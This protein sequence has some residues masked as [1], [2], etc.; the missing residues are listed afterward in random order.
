M[1]NIEKI[2]FP[3]LDITGANY[4]QWTGYVKRHLKSIG[5][6]ATIQEGNK[7]TEETKAKVDVFIHQHI[8]EMLEYEWN[9]LR[10]QYFKK[11][12]EYTS[13]L[14]RICRALRF[15]GQTVTE[16]DMLEKT[17]STFH[18]SNIN[19]Q[20][21]YRLQNFKRYSDLNVNRLI[22]EKNKELLMRNH[23]NRP[24]GSLAIPEA[25]VVNNK[26]TKNLEAKEDEVTLVGIVVVV[27]IMVT[28]VFPTKTIVTTE[29]VIMDV[30][31]VVVVIVV[32]EITLTMLHKLIISVRK[33]MKLVPP[34]T[35]KEPVSGVEVQITSLKLVAHLH[36]YVSFT[37]HLIKEK[38][39]KLGHPGSTMIK[40]IVENTHGHPLKDQKFSKIDKAP[41]CTSCS[42]E[43]LIVRPSQLKIKNE[44]PMFLE[45]IQVKRVRLDNAGEFISHAFND[46]YMS[47]GIVVEHP[48]ARVYT[49]NGLAELLIKRLQLIARPL[50]MRTKL[51]VSMW[52]HA[53][54]HA[55]SLI[56]MR[57][58]AD[59]KYSSIQLAFGQEPYIS[60]LRI[61]G[62]SVYV[63]I[64]PPQ[65]TKMGPQRRL[66]IYVRYETSS[67]IR[68]VEPLM[69]DV[70]T[71]CFADCHFNEVIFPPLGGEKKTHKKD[72]SWSE[73]FL[74]YLDPRTKQNTKRVT[75]SHISAANAPARVE[76][77][78]KQAV[79][80]VDDLNIIGTIKE[81]NEV[82]MHLKEEFEMKDLG[83][84]KYCLGL[85]IEHMPNGILVHQSNYTKT[86]LK[87]L[88]MDKSKPLSTP[89]EGRSLNVDND[90]FLPCKESEDVLGLEVSYL[91]AI[92]ALMYLT[93]CTRPACDRF[94]SVL[95]YPGCAQSD[96]M[97][98][99]SICLLSIWLGQGPNVIVRHSPKGML[100]LSYV[101]TSPQSSIFTACG[102]V[103]HALSV[104]ATAKI[105][106]FEI[107]YR[108]HGYVP[109]VGLFHRFYVNSKNKEMDLFAFTRHADPTKIKE[110]VP[111]H[112]SSSMGDS[113]GTHRCCAK[114]SNVKK[115][116]VELY[117]SNGLGG[118]M[119]GS[120]PLSSPK[121]ISKDGQ[122]DDSRSSLSRPH[123]DVVAKFLT[124][125]LDR[126]RRRRFM[127][128]TPSPVTNDSIENIV[129]D[130]L[131]E[132]SGDADQGDRSEGNDHEEKK[133]H[134]GASGSNHL[135][136]KLRKDHGTFGNVSAN[137]NGKS[138]AVIQELFERS[139]LNIEIG[140]TATK[141]V[142]FITSST[143]LIILV[144]MLQMLRLLPLSVPVMTATVTTTIIAN[145][146]F[147]PL[148]GAGAELA[149][150][151]HQSIFAD[152]ASIGTAGP[153][154]TGPSHPAGTEIFADTFYVSHEMDFETLRQIYAPTWNAINKSILGDPDVYPSLVDQLAPPGLFS[155]LRGMDYDQLFIEFNVKVLSDH[156]AGLD[157]E[158]MALETHL[159]KEFYPH[160]LTTIAVIGLA[161]DK[162]MQTWLVVGIDH[163][164]AERGLADVAAYDP[165]V[166]AKYVSTDLVF[167]DL[168]FDLLSQLEWQK[169][170]S[171]IDI[172][173]YLCL[174]GPSTE[175]LK[176]SLSDSLNVVHDHV[177]KL[178]EGAMSHRTSISNAIGTLVDPLSLKNLIGKAGTS[179]VPAT[180]ATATALSIS[181]VVAISSSI[182]PISVTDYGVPPCL[183][184]FIRS[185]PLRVYIPFVFCMAGTIVLVY[186]ISWLKAC[187]TDLEVI[188]FF[189]FAMLFA[190]RIAACSLFSSKR[191]RLS[192]KASSFCIMSILVVLKVGMPI[193]VGITA[194]V[195]N[196][197]ENKVSPLLDLIMDD[198]PVKSVHGSESFS[199][200]SMGAARESSSGRST[201]KS[202]KICPLIDTLCIP[203]VVSAAKLPILNPNEF[204]LLKMRIKQYFLMTDYSLWEVILNGDSPAP[205]RVIEGVLQPLKF[206]THKDAKTLM[207]ATEK[208]GHKGILEQMDL[209][210]YDLICPKVECY[211]CHR[212]GHF[213]SECRSPKDRRRNGAAEPQR[214][215]VPVETST[216]NA[217][218]SQFDG[219]SSYD[220]SFQAEEEPT[221]YALMA[222]SS[223]SS[224]SDNELR[225]NALV[226][227]RQNLEKAKQERDDLK[228]KLEKFQ[229]S[230][231]NLSELLA[232]QTNDKTGLGYNFQV[233]TRA[234]FDC[235]DYLSSGSDES[236]HPSPIYDRYQSDNGYYVVP[237]PYTGTFMPPKPDLVFNNAPNDVETDRLAFTV[238]ISP[239]K[240]DQELSHT[241][242][243]SAP[244]I[245]DW[246]SD[247]KDESET[248]TPQNTAIPKPISNG[249][250]KNRK[251]CFVCK[252]L[253]HLIKVCDY[254][255]KK[256]AQPTARNHA[257]KGTHKQY[258]QMTL[259]Y[260]HRHV[261]RAAVLT[262]SKLVPITVVRPVSTA[263]PKINVT[264]T[265]QAKTIVT[266]TNSPPRR[267]I[268]RSPSPKASTFP[269]K[270]TTVE[271]P[272][273]NPQHA[274][275]DKGIIDSRC[276]RHMT[277]NMSYL[278][279]FK[280]LNGGYVAFGENPKGGKISGKGKIR[281]G[282]LDFDDVYIFKELKF[283]LF[284]V[285][286]MC[287][288][289]NNVLFT[290]TE[291][292][293]LFPEFKLPNENQVLL[294]V[295]KENNM[296]N[297]DLKN[298]VPSGDLTY[299]F[300]KATL[301][302]SNL[303]HRRLGHINLKTMN[304]LIKDSLGKFNGKVDERFLVRYSVTSNGPI[305]LFDIDTLTKT[306]NYQPVTAGNQSNPSACKTDGDAA[307]DEKEPEFKGRK[308][309][310]EVNVSPSNSAQ[311][312][313]HDDKTKR[314]AKGKSPD[315]A[316][317]TL[318]PVV[319][320]LFPNNTN[321]F[322]AT[323][324]SNAAASPTHGKSS[325]IDTSQYPDDL[326]MLELEDIT[327]SNDEEDVGVE[328]DFNNLETSITVL[329]DL[330][331]RKR[332]IGTKW[333]FMNKKDERGIVFRNKAPLVAQGHTQEEGVDYEEVVSPIA[334]IEAIRLF[335]AYVSF[336][337]FMVYQM[338]VK[339]AFM[340][341]TI[342]EDVCFCQ[343]LGFEDPDYPGKVYKVVKVLYGLHQ[344]PRAWYETL[345]NYLLENGFQRGK[346][347][348]TLFIKRQKCE[349]LLVQIYVDDI[350]L[351][352]TNKDLCKAFEKFMKD[353]F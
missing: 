267:H 259:P 49:Q 35:S 71:T 146:S 162:G 145:V 50:I 248:T 230:S 113:N 205:T 299:L 217:L 254:H 93:N 28:T 78:N 287:D 103:L 102:V 47:I 64:A 223:S 351:G 326:N 140:V 111:L 84:T 307:L 278:F 53:I 216:S 56:H 5:A 291:C 116:V 58:S 92:G 2:K 164:K 70:F 43:K 293:I 296:Y 121:L 40:R 283:N 337:G 19:L 244:I 57:P 61:F 251:A 141:T 294:R 225:D 220:W 67:I 119:G 160:F 1:L 204:D 340:Y 96:Y 45:R 221:N 46:Y 3:A 315:N 11:V 352:S 48:V 305:W 274:L 174:E 253:D 252:S 208:R 215:S 341:G 290:D 74:L 236:L 34:K 322:S 13:V 177:Q 7:C 334:R 325:C 122:L 54:L 255:E 250:R 232:S 249:T 231:K 241:H 31:V 243:P 110:K 156:V 128:T 194:S 89:M 6:L 257:K 26:D 234:M 227:L 197:S 168:H 155:Q 33:I 82:V 342:E 44:L 173:N 59:H 112:L 275:K 9:N 333:V 37:K 288:K 229:T 25:N 224:S 101:I 88:N 135:P 87:H 276:S 85:R 321:T 105:S 246:V 166:K 346:I 187:V 190:S 188:V 144:Q 196:V 240:P 193:F 189:H 161:I 203:Q 81:I 117:A 52:G 123:L 282:K 132:E 62:C 134:C 77:P 108:V 311:S 24:T 348:Q 91:S 298:I 100:H 65:R 107:L 297:V 304:K 239:P 118:L 124:P 80:Y 147:A 335:L 180:A 277:R 42:L 143:L 320:Q 350:I 328:A 167:R 171:I 286:Q 245:E 212:N 330:P 281:T 152:F 268:N 195:P 213:A 233:F 79:V 312:K 133:S 314:E 214:R 271:A 179:E 17:F 66:G 285:S 210:P 165:F 115:V 94:T 222:F 138:L 14:L 27:A 185:L 270:V 279:D 29:V 207:E 169:D 159:D 269:P 125:S 237:P 344:S 262:Q 295:P 30:V 55:A 300:A 90:P 39:K 301:D 198:P 219:V 308:P 228:L 86:V 10:F 148:L 15:C 151:V 97:L 150:Q 353:K 192:F 323:G 310:S 98:S 183:G 8:D 22:A 76:L 72:V 21:Q 317:G 120:R 182:P 347:D 154:I 309:E 303:W 238:K 51:P 211:N 206:N 68:Y 176:S 339:S 261:V 272:M 331:H 201:M 319:R 235:D 338:D 316:A 175:T 106:Q 273:G 343:P 172:M 313:K 95:L 332:A 256:M 329:V 32:K 109:T 170:A 16:G 284:S 318:V 289:K 349:I 280:E 200:T 12:N 242:K 60:H 4:I 292:L 129:H 142:P 163:E 336:M 83:K 264:S 260:P 186:N 20:Q 263:I 114:E 23:Q 302:E 131:H 153:A 158:L 99:G 73:P 199:L 306:M 258:A 41:L 191:S 69:G 324:P 327:Y 75:K 127:L 126:S 36:I 209:L 157:S 38:R 63:P 178:N 137:T 265:R 345:A 130:G 181:V 149:T 218:V 247:S 18:A 266:K 184:Y 202:A 104:I 139:T 136:K 226:S